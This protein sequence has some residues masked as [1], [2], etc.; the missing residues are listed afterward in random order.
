AARLRG[1]QNGGGAAAPAEDGARGIPPEKQTAILD[2]FVRL[3]EAA[4]K[5][6]FGL[7]LSFVAAVAEW[8]GS[9]L[10]LADNRPGLRATLYFPAAGEGETKQPARPRQAI[11]LAVGGS[12]AQSET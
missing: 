11:P 8:H 3:E 2:R 1:E 7:G 9:R 4:G 6:G 5:E 10:E 12:S